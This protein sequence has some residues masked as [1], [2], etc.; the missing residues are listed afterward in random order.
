MAASLTDLKKGTHA[1]HYKIIAPTRTVLER[2]MVQNTA[3]LYA[4]L[5][6]NYRKCLFEVIAAK[7]GLTSY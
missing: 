1:R 5:I 4:A 6:C 2:G 3:D 7:G